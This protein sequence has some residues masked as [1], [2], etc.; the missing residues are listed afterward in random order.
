MEFLCEYLGDVSHSNYKNCDNTSLRPFVLN[1]SVGIINKLA[2]FR[3]SYF[4]ELTVESR[5]S[6]IVNGVASSFYGVTTVGNVL[7]RSKY[8][9]GGDFP[10]FLLK[11]TLKAFRH[12]YGQDPFDLILY[13]PSTESGDLV[14]NFTEKLSRILKVPIS[15]SLIKT[16]GT[17]PQKVFN[18]SYLKRDNVSGKFD[19]ENPSDIV[20]KSVIL[21]D[22][23]FDSG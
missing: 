1:P 3:E 18:N 21:F 16:G 13:V 5:S 12:R 15:H 22:D 11:M 14:K 23:I 4:P 20:G 17:K 2:E 6:N 9:N 10:D 19:F 7:H 8:E